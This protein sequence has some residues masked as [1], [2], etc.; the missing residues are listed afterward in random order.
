[1]KSNLDVNFDLFEKCAN[2]LRFQNKMNEGKQNKSNLCYEGLK[3]WDN[4]PSCL[5]TTSLYS[6][7][8]K[9]E[10]V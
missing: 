10:I 3:D 1:M 4:P 8:S 6:Y 2:V 7:N 5:I 9:F